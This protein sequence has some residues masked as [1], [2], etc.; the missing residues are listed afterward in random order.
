[1]PAAFIPK[2]KQS[3]DA[4]SSVCYATDTSH[5]RLFVC[6]DVLGWHSCK[7]RGDVIQGFRRDEALC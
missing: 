2:R 6:S 7:G 5:L 4:L 1:M 3:G